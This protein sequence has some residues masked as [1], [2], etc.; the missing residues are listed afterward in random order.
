MS[1]SFCQFS[2]NQ[3]P[4]K[5]PNG[6]TGPQP[7]IAK[8]VTYGHALPATLALLLSQKSQHALRLLVGLRDHGGAG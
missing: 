8:N 6:D 5:T 4:V 1:F 2:S 3:L 7:V